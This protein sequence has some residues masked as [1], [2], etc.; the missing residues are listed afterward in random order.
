MSPSPDWVVGV[1]KLNL[2]QRDC[3]WLRSMT[4]DLY[5]WDAGT[6]N[7]ITYLSANSETKPRERMKPI[8]TMYPEDP[9]S[10][11]YDPSGKP[12]LPVAR[13]YLFREEIIKKSSCD[14]EHDSEIDL[15]Q[16]DNDNTAD[17]ADEKRE[18]FRTSPRGFS[19]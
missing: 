12:M 13:L 6:D 2:C 9:R 17:D 10:P 18:F 15:G 3:S 1:S 8:T 11:F 14:D 19:F 7:G 4:I 5:P 16:F